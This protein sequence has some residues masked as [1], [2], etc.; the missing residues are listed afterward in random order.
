VDRVDLSLQTLKVPYAKILAVELKEISKEL[1]SEVSGILGGDFYSK[2][3]VTI[4]YR[5]TK[6]IFE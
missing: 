6:L 4:D 3:K 2:R 5:N 1:R